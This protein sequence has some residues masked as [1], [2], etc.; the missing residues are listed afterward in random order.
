MPT[1]RV[2]RWLLLPLALLSLATATELLPNITGDVTLTT[3]NPPVV[4]CPA[5]AHVRSTTAGD[6]GTVLHASR[7]QDAAGATWVRHVYRAM[8][9]IPVPAPATRG[10]STNASQLVGVHGRYR[11]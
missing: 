4:G 7:R 8:A 11:Y 1:G 3:A 9:L 6:S 10:S 5:V 2:A